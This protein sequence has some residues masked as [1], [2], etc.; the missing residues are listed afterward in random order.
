[1][2]RLMCDGKWTV[3]PR[4]G[5]TRLGQA[6]TVAHAGVSSSSLPSDS[7][8]DVELTRFGGHGFL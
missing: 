2:V 7:R 1:V 4:T 3:V 5:G 6:D 8:G